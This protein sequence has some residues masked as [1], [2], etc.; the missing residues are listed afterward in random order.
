MSGLQV[1][2]ER[3]DRD[4]K[5]V[6]LDSLDQHEEALV[7][8]DLESK[9]EANEVIATLLC[10]DGMV[11]LLSA[12]N[13]PSPEAKKSAS[14]PPHARNVHILQLMVGQPEGWKAFREWDAV[15]RQQRTG[16]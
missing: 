14:T 12:V 3:D 8:A 15:E 11:A 6:R 10:C 9:D 5:Y 4:L 2:E 16:L 13:L 7:S 1:S